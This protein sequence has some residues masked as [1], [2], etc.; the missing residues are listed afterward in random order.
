LSDLERRVRKLEIQRAYLIGGLVAFAA[1]VSALGF[2]TYSYIDEQIRKQ[3]PGIV[4]ER[5]KQVAQETIKAELPA[6]V[7]PAVE[8]SVQRQFED[9]SAAWNQSLNNRLESALATL[10]LQSA[11]QDL[12]GTVVVG[13]D[14]DA[15]EINL[16]GKRLSKDQLEH[17]S[18]FPAINDVRVLGLRNVDVDPD[19]IKALIDWRGLKQVD[20]ESDAASAELRAVLPPTIRIETG[21]K[22]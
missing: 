17:L 18:A 7:Q 8:Q 2:N 10:Q 12:G 6:Q 21:G 13:P 9:K 16:S 22:L 4:E 19:A 3:I 1:V 15:I 11:V 20:V 14:S 5:A